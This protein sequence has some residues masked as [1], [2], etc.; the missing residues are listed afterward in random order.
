ML[1]LDVIWSG[2][3]ARHLLDLRPCTHGIE[4][5][6][7]AGFIA[8]NT[9]QGHL[10]A[11]P[12]FAN[13]GLLFYRTDLLQKYKLAVPETWDALTVAARTVQDGERAAGNK[14]M[15]GYV[16]QGRAYERLTC[17]ALQWVASYGGGSIVEPD[18]KI[19]INNPSAAHALETAARWTGSIAPT[20]VLNY[21]E[22]ES[23]GV[24]QAG[25]ALFM[26]NWPYAW[27]LALAQGTDSVIRDKV[28]AAVL[29][30]GTGPAARHGATLGGESLAVSRYSRHSAEAA[31]LVQP[32]RHRTVG[33]DR[34]PLRRAGELQQRIR[35]V[36][37]RRMV[38][39]GRQHLH[40]RRRL[41][42]A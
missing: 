41:G 11:M 1:Q 19:S 40:I 34:R 23:R 25:N 42:D 36:A 3:F 13:A 7:L 14:S 18:G 20:A 12:W 17:N 8:N 16:F 28:G 39:V 15:W 10:V 5:Q 33:A 30:M 29:P 4:K 2:L 22:V 6:Y 26:R 27:A 37:R 31:D 21:A 38:A 35:A 9:V 24:F 32:D